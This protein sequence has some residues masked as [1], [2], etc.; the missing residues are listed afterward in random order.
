MS[1]WETLSFV[2]ADGSS[3]SISR[4]LSND[5][6]PKTDEILIGAKGPAFDDDTAWLPHEAMDAYLVRFSDT[7]DAG[8]I[9]HVFSSNTWQVHRHD[10]SL[11]T[12]EIGRG[13]TYDWQK[14]VLAELPDWVKV[15]GTW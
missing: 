5:K 14:D 3:N 15:G 1:R 13:P 4:Y 2:H 12:A 6:N 10:E 8:A 11:W 7:S 9:S